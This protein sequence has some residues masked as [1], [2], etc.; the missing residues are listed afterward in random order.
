MAIGLA[1]TAISVGTKLYAAHKAEE[2]ANRQADL[3]WEVTQEELR[4]MDLEQKQIMGSS[5]AQIAASGLEMGSASLKLQLEGMQ[6]EFLREREFTA[7]M[8]AQ[9]AS[10][11]REAGRDTKYAGM[12]GA[13]GSA[14]GGYDKY[15][16]A[17]GSDQSW[18]A[19]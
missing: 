17:N 9:K 1:L 11:T 4:R 14:L 8:G 2:D 6:E 12:V 7:N 13:A 3:D 16:T 18:W 5:K 19:K 15:A 10:I